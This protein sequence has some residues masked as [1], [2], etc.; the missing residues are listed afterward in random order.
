[1][2]LYDRFNGK[3]VES[4]SLPRDL[5]LGRYATEDLR[6]LTNSIFDTGTDYYIHQE[7]LDESNHSLHELFKDLGKRVSSRGKNE[8]DIFPLIQTLEDKLELNDFEKYLCEKLPHLEQICHQPHYLLQRI[9]EKVNASRAKRIPSKS[10]QYLA[11]HTEDWE[12]K[13]I[14]NFKPNRVLNEELD[15]NYNVYENQ[16][17]LSLVERC[18]KYLN[19]RLKEVKDISVFIEKYQELLEKRNDTHAWFEKVSRNLTLIGGVYEDEN[20]SKKKNNDRTKLVTTEE[21]LR[22]AYK[23]LLQIRASELFEEVNKRAAK[24]VALRDTNVLINHKHYR[25]VRSLW[26]ELNKIRPEKTEE[27][28]KI[29]EQIVIDG[30]RAYAKTLLS[31]T[32]SHLNYNENLN[33]EIAG[34]YSDWEAVN[35]RL[36]PIEFHEKEDKTFVVQ[37]GGYSLR[38]IVIGNIS[39]IDPQSLPDRTYLLCFS[40]S[41]ADESGKMIAID[42]M[43]PDSVE[44]LGAV[45]NKYLLAEYVVN[46]QHKY[47]FPQTLRDF[48]CYIDAPWIHFNNE[49]NHY[50]YSFICPGTPVNKKAISSRLIVGR[51][52]RDDQKK[53]LLKLIDDIERNYESFIKD[54]LFCFHCQTQYNESTIENFNYLSCSN[55]DGFTLDISQPGRIILKNIDERFQTEGV[56]W[57]LDCLDFRVVDL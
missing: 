44:R 26:L 34:T 43:D 36:A 51:D 50:T 27:D 6:D 53:E 11:A 42:P 13:S 25:Y 30:L 14:V 48:I 9:I 40:Q 20:Y 5:D 45:V 18:L 37:I 33:Y 15:L 21:H 31:Y 46:I 41:K 47:P 55:D 57:G 10:Y 3:Y 39:N 12:Q 29:D 23:K 38:L 49:H 4:R 56:D 22:A 1:M 35:A 32:V 54:N 2:R 24:N 7:L 16:L 8:M 28:L 19:G 17:F 52:I